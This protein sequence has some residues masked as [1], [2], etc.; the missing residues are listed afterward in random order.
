MSAE[1][2]RALAYRVSAARR[3]GAESARC[4]R[5][6]GSSSAYLALRAGTLALLD[7]DAAGVPRQ[8]SQID[9]GEQEVEDRGC[10]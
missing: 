7:I 1:E 6:V 2:D 8:G 9:G 3:R 5:L 10:P 4:A